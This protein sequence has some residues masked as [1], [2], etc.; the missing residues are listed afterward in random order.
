[1]M[2]QQKKKMRLDELKV[3]SFVTVDIKST[4]GGYSLVPEGCLAYESDNWCASVDYDDGMCNAQTAPLPPLTFPTQSGT[5]GSTGPE[6]FKFT[7]PH[8]PHAH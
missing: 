3:D 5:G 6:T 4:V 7:C 2:M 1:M 8:V